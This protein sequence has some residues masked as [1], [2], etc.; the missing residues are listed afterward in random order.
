MATRTAGQEAP[1]FHLKTLEGVNVTL[2]EALAKGPAVVAFFKIG[3]PTCQ[4]TF[5]FL[6]RMFER[7]GGPGWT[8]WG[9]SQNAADKTRAFCA[10]FGVRFP[11]LLD[12]AGYIASNAYGITNVPTI[13]LIAP[14]GTIRLSS[15][16]FAKHEI[17]EVAAAAA[18]ASG[19][20]VDAQIA[21]AA[22]FRPGESVPAFKPG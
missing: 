16:G 15:V 21:A 12:D 18:R 17:E 7:F 2:A 11:V 9:I 6:Q 3:C 22:V 1:A 10:E 14:D 5:P 20:T 8:L 13:F 19:N 4:F